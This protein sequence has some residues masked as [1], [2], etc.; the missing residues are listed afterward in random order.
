MKYFL[1]LLGVLL[2]IIF[3]LVLAFGGGSDTA[4]QKDVKRLADYATEPATTAI[5]TQGGAINSVEDHRVIRVSVTDSVRRIE[6][7][8]GYDGDVLKTKTYSN[9]TSAFRAF[10]AGLEQVG[11]SRERSTSASFESVCPESRRFRYELDSNDETVINTWSASCE[12]GTF[13]GRTTSVQNLFE[14]QIPEYDDYTK[15]VN[16]SLSQ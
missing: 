7:L 4:T 6:I 13:N 14:A 1:G 3:I 16:F 11:F 8:E 2:L 10:L 9:T 5:L 12:K 15:N